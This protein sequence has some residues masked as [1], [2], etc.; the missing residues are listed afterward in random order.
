[1]STDPVVR[2]EQVGKRYSLGE[3]RGGYKLLSETI[4]ERVRQGGRLRREREEFWALR[5]VGFEVE[6]GETFGI[7]G[8]NGA[9]KSTLLKILSRVTPPTTGSVEL[10]G[11]VGALLEVG[12]GFHPELTGRDNVFLNGAILG[13]TRQEIAR[14]FDEIVAF[15]EVERFI[16]TP[17]K[18]YSS[19]MQL[20]LAFAVAAHLEPEILII[21]EVLSVGDLAFQEKCLGRMEAVSGE[22]R[23]VL[24]VSHN[25]TAVSNLCDRSMLLQSGSKVTEGPTAE[26]IEAYVRSVVRETGTAL[27][28]R[29]DRH[30]NG[31]LRFTEIA[32]ETA[33]RTVDSPATGED[34]E[35][36]LRYETVDGK[37]A[38]NVSFAV[39]VLTL[40]GDVIVHFYTRTAGVQITEAPGIG[41]VRCVVPR[42][43]LPP[44]Q[45][46]VTLWA[47]QGGDPVDW[48]QRACELTVREGDFYR[49]GQT[50]LPSHQSVLVDHSWSVSATDGTPVASGGVAG[51][52]TR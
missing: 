46:M 25:L 35:I 31:R 26:V 28:D 29:T 3:L 40:L 4:S 16:D 34:F 24:F 41:E 50:Q 21:D 39:Q 8:H 51:V 43:P 14:K 52:R 49:S 2:A 17:V 5:D 12:T 15:A 13:M 47:D 38:R 7:V 18:R 33:G 48:I 23:T 44:G 42:C 27:T 1:M 45:Y 11:R 36:V 9:G 10:R 32:F 20:R 30:G 37:P 22:G 19:G 6:Q